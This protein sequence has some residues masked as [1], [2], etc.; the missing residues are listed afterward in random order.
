M[1]RKIEHRTTFTQPTYEHRKPGIA[2][3]DIVEQL[4]RTVK[5]LLT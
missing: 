4:I 5:E 2:S 3:W 1:N